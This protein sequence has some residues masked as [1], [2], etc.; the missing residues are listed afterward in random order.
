MY[1]ISSCLQF[2]L[3]SFLSLF[4]IWHI[5]VTITFIVQQMYMKDNRHCYEYLNVS[6]HFSTKSPNDPHISASTA[7]AYRSCCGR[8]SFHHL[9]TSYA[10]LLGLCYH[11]NIADPSC[12]LSGPQIG[13]SLRGLSLDCT[14]GAGAF[15]SCCL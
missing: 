4:C 5:C 13:G 8:N 11:S 15:P 2:F 6:C 9:A 1:M 3:N 12:D 14:V 7:N 10:W